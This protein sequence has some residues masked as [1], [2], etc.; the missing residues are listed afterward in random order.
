[1]P[2]KRP[3]GG[4]CRLPSCPFVAM[5]T[6]PASASTNPAISR[7]RGARHIWKHVQ[8]MMTIKPRRSSTVPM[9]AFV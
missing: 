8:N 9:P 4:I 3:S 5:S 2:K 6:V 7:R 1:M